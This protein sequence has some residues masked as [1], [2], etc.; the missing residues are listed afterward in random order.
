MIKKCNSNRAIN[1]DLESIKEKNIST[2]G[3]VAPLMKSFGKLK[4][5]NQ[6]YDA[7]LPI[8]D[9][10]LTGFTV[11]L[12]KDR[13]G[14]EQAI[15]SIMSRIN[16]HAFQE[17]NN[18]L[19]SKSKLTQSELD[20]MNSA[21]LMA[22]TEQCFNITEEQ[23]D[24]WEAMSI[25]QELVDYMLNKKEQFVLSC[26]DPDEQEIAVVN[27]HKVLRKTIAENNR[28]IYQEILPTVKNLYK[29]SHPLI[30]S[31]IE[32]ALN[33]NKI[34]SKKL[35]VMGR[36]I[37]AVSGE[38]IVFGII[39]IEAIGL[40]RRLRSQEGSFRLRNLPEGE[41]VIRCSHAEYKTHEFRFIHTWGTTT[42]LEL[43]LVPVDNPTPVPS[44]S[45][46][47]MEEV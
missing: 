25:T 34:S 38:P 11:Q 40:K 10:D 19:Y 12:H 20:R 45:K 37:D 23:K 13:S 5:Y 31:D 46:P 44:S 39:E 3:G 6:I 24:N 42:R 22:M 4:G 16:L 18:V 26:E 32:T 8:C 47:E 35:A 14:L 2:V 33:I 15:I 29:V 27:A 1:I 30:V 7:Y 9:T 17:E 21:Q 28:T 41:Y 43:R 36:V